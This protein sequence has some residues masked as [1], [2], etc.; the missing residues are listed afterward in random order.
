MKTPN[1]WYREPW[2][3]IIMSGPAVVVVAGIATLVIAIRT[4]DG[5]VADDYYKQGLAVNKAVERDARAAAL[6]LEAGLVFNE[7]HDRV[8]VT[9]TGQA[10]PDRLVLRLVHPTRSGEDQGVSL[11]HLGGGLYEGRIAPPG[12]GRWSVR[13]EDAEGTWRLTRTWRNG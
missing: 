9:L 1:P 10:Q 13:I 12:S 3:W 5:V 8:R 11:A 6:N 7:E 2:P 4:N